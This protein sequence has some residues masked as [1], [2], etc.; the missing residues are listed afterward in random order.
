MP[1]ACKGQLVPPDCGF[2]ASPVFPAHGP[3]PRVPCVSWHEPPPSGG[4][5]A[6]VRRNEAKLTGTKAHPS[7][8]ELCPGEGLR[9]PEATGDSGRA[10]ALRV[11]GPTRVVLGVSL[12]LLLSILALYLVLR[13]LPAGVDWLAALRHA[14]PFYLLVS[15]LLLCASW[16]ADAQRLKFLATGLGR[17]VRMRLLVPGIMAGNFLTLSTPFA[18]GGAPALV[19]LLSR[20]GLSLGQASAVVVLGGVSSQLALACFNLLAALV[21]ASHL[22]PGALLGRAYLT[23]V[24]GYF[25]AII[26]FVWLAQRTE[27][28]RP[29]LEALL[30]AGDGAGRGKWWTRPA[31]LLFRLLEDFRTS[32]GLLTAQK[33]GVLALSFGCALAY[34]LLYFAVGIAVLAALRVSGSVLVL[35][36]WQIVAATAALFVPVPGGSGAAELSA[37]YALGRVVPA[38]VLPAFVILWRLFTFHLNL[39]L[40]GIAAAVLARRLS[41]QDGGV[42]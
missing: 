14:S 36:A 6:G 25:A 2:H 40:G 1:A 29:R 28:L 32:V 31:L 34:F 39:T 38:A 11:P 15:F 4:S 19:Y 24:A 12:A 3:A 35:F 41:T 21:L 9:L 7:V 42:A 10:G 17:P 20:E 22:P 13:H 23:L 33:A 5:R 16:V 8:R 18:A 26:G 37:A 27:K 30:G